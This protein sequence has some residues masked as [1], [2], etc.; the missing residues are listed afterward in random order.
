MLSMSEDPIAYHL[1]PVE[2][3]EAS[4][5]GEPYRARSLETDGFIHLTGR[6]ADLVEVGDRYYR[7][8]PRP[9]VV[10]TVARRWVTAP[11]RHD[12]DPRYPHVYGPIEREAIT[13]V[14]P[15]ERTPEGR[16]LQIERPDE[17]RPPDTPALLQRL[18]EAGVRF[19]V[20]GSSAA[21]LLGADLAPGDLDVCPDPDR[22]NLERIAHVL[23]DLGALPRIGIPGW[24]TEEDRA[25][26]HPS[27]DVA[28]LDFLFETPLGDLD[29]VFH[30][31]QPGGPDFDFETLQASAVPVSVGGFAVL[32][33][34]PEHLLA[35][36]LGA[37]R[38]KDLR[39][40]TELERIA[41]RSEASNRAC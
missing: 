24:V 18:H 3:W 25:A 26:Y 19:V 1:V 34:S 13:E 10:L 20:I 38:P 23:V 32:V 36:K 12:G 8:D 6:M 35:S 17:R 33:A 29:L 15:I 41:S 31:L 9:Y 4:P 2:E 7:D 28:T 27:A 39:A 40:R 22:D 14:R 37:P 16:F 11:W 5:V 21:A 30:P